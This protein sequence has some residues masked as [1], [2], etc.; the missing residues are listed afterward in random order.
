MIDECLVAVGD[1]VGAYRLI[2]I[3][4]DG[5]TLEWQTKT[6]RLELGVE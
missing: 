5:V 4:A 1:D 6:Y 2:A 3:D